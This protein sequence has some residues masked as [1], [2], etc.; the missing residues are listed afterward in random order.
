MNKI[1]I[2]I[3]IFSQILYAQQGDTSK[4]DPLIAIA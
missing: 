2:A 3:L 1:L 4:D